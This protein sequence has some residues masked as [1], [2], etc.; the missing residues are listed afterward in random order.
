[1]RTEEEIR[2]M[3]DAFSEISLPPRDEVERRRFWELVG[4]LTHEDLNQIANE[5]FRRAAVHDAA[6]ASYLR[7]ARLR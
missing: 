6:A 4:P 7:R 5:F 1:M 2:R 3:A